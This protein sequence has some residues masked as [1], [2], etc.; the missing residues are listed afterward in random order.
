MH[1]GLRPKAARDE[2]LAY[3]CFYSI[4]SHSIPLWAVFAVAREFSFAQIKVTM[5]NNI[6][7][8]KIKISFFHNS[9]VFL[10]NGIYTKVYK[11]TKKNTA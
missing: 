5:P 1:K 7:I 4:N 6:S 9:R 10:Q 3:A 8:P 2:R 11:H